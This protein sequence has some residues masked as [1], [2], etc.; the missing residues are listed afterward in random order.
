M[1][2]PKYDKESQNFSLFFVLAFSAA[3]SLQGL[4]PYLCPSPP[5]SPKFTS[6]GFQFVAQSQAKA[7][8][9]FLNPIQCYVFYKV[10][11]IT[12]LSPSKL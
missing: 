9:S 4:S 5:L 8:H 3:P 7:L 11:I 10:H 12:L 6:Q 1:G 2:A